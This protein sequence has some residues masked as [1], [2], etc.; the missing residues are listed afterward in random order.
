M[1]LIGD[2]MKIK[3]VYNRLGISEVK[4]PIDKYLPKNNN[5]L[6][7][8]EFWDG[9]PTEGYLMLQKNIQDIIR[10]KDVCRFFGF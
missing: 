9:G 1:Y 8:F 2:A 7:F 10:N 5:V 6:D 3:E 4:P